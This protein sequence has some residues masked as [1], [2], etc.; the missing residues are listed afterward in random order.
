MR[1]ISIRPF[2]AAAVA[3]VLAGPALADRP[4]PGPEAHKLLAGRNFE[5]VCMDGTRGRASYEASGAMAAVFWMSNRRDDA[6]EQH[7]SGRARAVGD[8]VCMSWR[9]LT[10]GKEECF[11]MTERKPGVYR[12]ATYNQTIWCDFSAQ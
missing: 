12:L 5:F 11:R 2:A 10:G 9:N 1:M 7:D 3:A 6:M 8:N 4:V